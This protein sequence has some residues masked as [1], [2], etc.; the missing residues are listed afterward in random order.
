[1][2]DST[3]AKASNQVKIENEELTEALKHVS[4]VVDDM[5]NATL[6]QVSH[7]VRTENE[8]LT[9]TLNHVI[10]DA[11]IKAAT[12]VQGEKNLRQELI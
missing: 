4:G 6:S 7:E 9:E 1:M 5:V 8:F 3:L 10:G 12:G 11:I 2:V